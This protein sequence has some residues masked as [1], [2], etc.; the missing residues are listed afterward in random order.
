MRTRVVLALVSMSLAIPLMTAAQQNGARG[1]AAPAQGQGRGGRG[2]NGNV[3][4]RGAPPLVPDS[5]P[6]DARDLSGVWLGNKYG[7]NATLEP[8]MTA[9]GKKRFDAQKPSYGARVGTPA[10]A[11]LKVPSGRRRAIPPA[12][13]NDYVGA[14]NPLGLVRLLLYDPAPM[15]MITTPNRIIQRFEWTWDHREIWLDGR[16]LPNVDAYL[17][18]WTGYSVGRWE[19]NTL[20]VTTVGLDDRQWLDHFGYPISDRARVDERWTRKYH[21]IM[22]L[23]ITVTDPVIYTQP[24]K[25]D[26]VTFRLAA[27]N[28]LST[29][30][31]W[32]SIAE[33]KC[34]PLDEVQ[35]Y[36]KLVRNPAGGVPGVDHK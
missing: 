30:T 10:A 33:D 5:Q 2:G 19:V 24:W 31:G 4:G 27:A 1:A 29:G 34:V 22:E 8:P 26:L 25:S 3:L 32:A 35:Q 20:V 21:N 14:C 23:E 6:F 16:E 17:P 36:N 9:E 11:D 15:E 7:F 18:R 13:G 12:Q 28:D